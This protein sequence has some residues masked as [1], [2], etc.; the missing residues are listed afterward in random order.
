[1]AMN[2]L[3]TALVNRG[4]L[5][6]DAPQMPVVQSDRP[7]FIAFVVGVAGWLAGI[8]AMVF[9]GLLFQPDTTG[10]FA[11]SAVILLGSAYG[12]YAVDRESA[13]FDQLALALSIA[14][15]I[16]MLVAVQKM[17]DSTTLTCAIGTVLQVGLVIVMPNRLARVL[18]S[19]F[20]CLLW[21]LALRLVW[22]GEG[23]DDVFM[24]QRRLSL[25]PALLAWAVIWV[26]L[27]ALAYLL[28]FK[29]A[30]WMATRARK[31]LRPA[32][33]GLLIALAVGTFA[34][35]PVAAF[36]FSNSDDEPRT[37][38]LVLWP[39]LAVGVAMFAGYCALRVRNN[40][41][42]GVAIAGALVHV[43]QFYFLLGTT[44]LVKSVIML[45]V[46]G[47]LFVAGNALRRAA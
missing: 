13:F 2:E 6:A 31:I 32:L 7:W 11:V 16:A 39:L 38:W 29:E 27:M 43:M 47:L 25:A 8:S 18:S 5:P 35:E 21:V 20:A 36:D 37:D 46:G 26:P 40:A 23:A 14:G 30:T 4:L 12:L 41:L 10:E 28:V 44:L 1:M 45:I 15:Q 24:G 19:L 42:M 22:W 34:S 17:A 9:V 33:T 3:S